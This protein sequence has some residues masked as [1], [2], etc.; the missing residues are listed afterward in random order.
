MT[1]RDL[2]SASLRLIGAAAPGESLDAQVATDGLSALNRM[3]GSWNTEPLML[4]GGVPLAQVD[5]LDST[6]S[7]PDGYEDA[8]IYNLAVR[9]APE[10]GRMIPDAVALVAVESKAGV[11]RANHKPLYLEVD[12]ALLSRGGT[13]DIFTGGTA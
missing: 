4:P 8:L 10:Y 11:K 13:F 12:G 7:M 1:G 5:S 2:V 6:V 9:I 3:I